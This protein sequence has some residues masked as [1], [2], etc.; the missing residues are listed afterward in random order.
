MVTKMFKTE[1]KLEELEKR[2]EELEAINGIPR[3]EPDYI[4]SEFIRFVL[5]SEKVTIQ[6]ILNRIKDTTLA[7][8][9]LDLESSCFERVLSCVSKNRG[10]QILQIVPYIKARPDALE[11]V[12]L[13]KKSILLEIMKLERLG[14]SKSG[15]DGF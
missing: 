10:F 2:I 11:C 15:E 1:K 8:A 9:T 14:T 3:W 4:H 7:E 6:R 5:L 12:A 13:A